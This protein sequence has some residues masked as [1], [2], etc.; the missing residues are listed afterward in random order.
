MPEVRNDKMICEYAPNSISQALLCSLA[1][2]WNQIPLLNI[3]LCPEIHVKN[4]VIISNTLELSELNT[5][6]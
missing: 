3:Q 4:D 6:N 1:M 5:S 2:L